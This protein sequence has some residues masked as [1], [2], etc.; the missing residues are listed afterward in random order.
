VAAPL[1]LRLVN[2]R[3]RRSDREF[4]MAEADLDASPR[5]PFDAAKVFHLVGR[6]E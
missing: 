4:V 3:R 6:A 2:R 1:L 5:Q